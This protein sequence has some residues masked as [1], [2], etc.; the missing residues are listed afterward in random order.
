VSNL[1]FLL[2][3]ISTFENKFLNP[4]FPKEFEKEQAYVRKSFPR[5]INY[6]IRT[7]KNNKENNM[8]NA[9]TILESNESEKNKLFSNIDS[10]WDTYLNL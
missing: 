2:R 10:H 3:L 7:F 6:V 4:R 9:S 5:F 8:K 1:A